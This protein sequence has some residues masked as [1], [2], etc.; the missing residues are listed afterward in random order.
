MGADV[1]DVPLK[2]EQQRRYMQKVLEELRALDHMLKHNMIE[3]DTQRIGAEQ[4]LVLVDRAWRPAPIAL[5]VLPAIKDD[6]VVNELAMFNLEY[7]SDPVL[8]TGDCLFKLE[9]QLVHTLKRIRKTVQKYDA[10]VIITGILPSLAK[11]D[12][13]NHNLTPRARYFELDNA[14]KK[15][16]N[17]DPL[18]VAIKGIDELNMESDTIMTES[19]NTSFQVHFQVTPEDFAKYYNICQAIAGPVLASAV[20]SPMLLGKRLWRETRI[21]VFQQVLDTR[22]AQ[23]F[24][25]ELKPR[26]H[27]GNRWVES[28]VIEIY[29]E[30]ISNYRTVFTVDDEEDAFEKIHAGIPPKL[31]ALQLFN[32]SVY[33][34][35]RPCYGITDGKAHLRIENRCFPAGPTIIDEIANAAL[36]LGLVNGMVEKYEDITQ[37]MDFD[38]VYENFFAAATYGLETQFSWLDGEIVPASRLIIDQLLPIA[39]YGLEK[40]GI[41]AKDI[42]RYLSIIENRC[43]SGKTG[44]RWIL[45]SFS[46]L[47]TKGNVDE[48]LSAVSAEM[49]V[50]EKEGKP[51]HEWTLAQ[52]ESGDWKGSYQWVEQVMSRDFH[53]VGP[54]DP[55]DLV[56]SLML[57]NYVRHIA[58]EDDLHKL[59]GI[60]SYRS[61]LKMQLNGKLPKGEHPIAARELMVEN[62]LTIDPRTPVLEAMNLMRQKK[63]GCLPVVKNGNLIGILTEGDYTKIAGELLNERL[64]I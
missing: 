52:I 54:E 10:E 46:A 33:R 37:R 12:L 21:A 5:D 60:I 39:A 57:W 2:P 64:R 18:K 6:R 14:L 61:I 53:T 11:T 19:C 40:A 22:N 30:D 50:R 32:G 45:E 51:V 31:K 26:V 7:N 1:N 17:G 63:L 41:V 35:N 13:G 15:L 20:N 47:K 29:Q 44:A 16:R 49:N 36:W 62:P 4:E 38:V 25:R 8:F 59:L 34:W 42:D 9:K 3:S 23:S 55:L 43:Q 28:S 58:V 27:F 24:P 56:A 48:R